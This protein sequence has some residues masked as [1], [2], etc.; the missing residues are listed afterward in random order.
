MYVFSCRYMYIKGGQIRL[1]Q[2]LQL[3]GDQI[4]LC[5]SSRADQSSKYVSRVNILVVKEAFT[6]KAKRKAYAPSIKA[7]F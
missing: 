4:R 7:E 2:A 5:R 6:F 1:L 3:T